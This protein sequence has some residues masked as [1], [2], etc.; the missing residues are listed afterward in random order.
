MTDAATVDAHGVRTEPATVR[1]QRLLPGPIERVWAY[2]TES[3]LRRQW[4]AAG[5]MDLTPGG[6]V[7]LTWRNDELSP[8]ETRPDSM[9]AEHSMTSRIIRAEPPRLLAFTWNSG[10]VRFDLEPQGDEV[11]LTVTH[12][13]LP[14]RG[15]MLSVSAGWHAHLDVLADKLA[16][17]A[18]APFWSKWTRLR[19]EYEAR[20]PE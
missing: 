2:L 13:R 20:L 18:A 14:D 10:E 6:V 19:A 8:D 15:A 1:L 11:L 3:D 5:P 9:P 17:R 7:E 4:L 12:Q 16:G